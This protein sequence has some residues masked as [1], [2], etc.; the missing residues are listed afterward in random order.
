[1]TEPRHVPEKDFYLVLEKL[2]EFRR[3]ATSRNLDP[4]A[5]RKA[6]IVV[7]EIDTVCAIEKGVDPSELQKFDAYA[8]RQVQYFV[9]EVATA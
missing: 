6:I 8:R 1:L 2:R 9:K 4:Y 3:W 7:L 5:F